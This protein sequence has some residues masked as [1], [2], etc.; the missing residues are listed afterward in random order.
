M[1]KGLITGLKDMQE[2]TE[3]GE[4]IM[5]NMFKMSRIFGKSKIFLDNIDYSFNTRGWNFFTKTNVMFQ[6]FSRSDVLKKSMV[7][8][9]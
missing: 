8:Y 5:R 9:S 6:I 3:T 4:K 2:L 7:L 1:S